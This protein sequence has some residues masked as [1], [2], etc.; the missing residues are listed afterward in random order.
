MRE[1]FYAL[2]VIT[3]VMTVSG[4]LKRNLIMSNLLTVFSIFIIPIILMFI[5][6]GFSKREEGN[7]FKLG[8]YTLDGYP[9]EYRIWFT[10]NAMVY[11]AY[12]GVCALILFFI[13][14]L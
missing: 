7:S 4:I 8:S 14:V 12:Q 11:T 9:F 6:M 13:S 5:S 2:V 10:L 1:Y 3:S